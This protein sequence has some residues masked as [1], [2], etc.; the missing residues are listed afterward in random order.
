MQVHQ[1]SFCRHSP[2]RVASTCSSHAEDQKQPIELNTNVPS[3]TPTLRH[4]T[5]A[6]LCGSSEVCS[7]PPSFFRSFSKQCCLHHETPAGPLSLIDDVARLSPDTLSSVETWEMRFPSP[8]TST[9][10]CCLLN[11]IKWAV[12]IDINPNALLLTDGRSRDCPY[13]SRPSEARPRQNSQ[14]PLV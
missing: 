8:L 12:A 4:R 6:C 3:K 13:Y 5:N 7:S 1:T 11:H 10:Y 2:C 9:Y 14:S